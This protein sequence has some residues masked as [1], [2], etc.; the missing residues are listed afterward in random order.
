MATFNVVFKIF[1]YATPLYV[2]YQ[3]KQ[4][5]IAARPKEESHE[6]SEAHH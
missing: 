1:M 4:A 3:I 2:W 5:Q 6:A